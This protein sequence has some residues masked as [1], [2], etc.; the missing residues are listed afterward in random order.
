VESEGVARHGNGVALRAWTLRRGLAMVLRPRRD[1]HIDREGVC[2]ETWPKEAPRSLGRLRWAS[3]WA[4][5]P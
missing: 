4:A 1:R 5:R 2:C 3:A